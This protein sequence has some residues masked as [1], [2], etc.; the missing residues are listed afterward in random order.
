MRTK[1]ILSSW[2]FLECVKHPGGLIY[3]GTT[4][5]VFPHLIGIP[6]GHI[7]Q[8]VHRTGLLLYYNY[9]IAHFIV[10][11]TLQSFFHISLEYNNFK[12]VQLWCHE[13][14]FMD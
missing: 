10:L 1:D 13:Y 8:V 9:I 11:H 6:V 5:V 14:H 4:V 12:T 2:A 7:I 3:V